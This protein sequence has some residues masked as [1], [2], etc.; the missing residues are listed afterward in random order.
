M[1]R[2]TRGTRG[3]AGTAGGSRCAARLTRRIGR[4]RR[5][6]LRWRYIS[7]ARNRPLAGARP[8]RRCGYWSV[9]GG[10]LSRRVNRGIQQHRVFTDET[11]T[12]PVHLHEES[13]EWLCNGVRGLELD[14]LTTVR[15]T[16][17]LHLHAAEKNGPIQAVSGERLARSDL[18]LERLHL[19]RR[20]VHQLDFCIERRIER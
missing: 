8:R 19:L 11:P 1:S 15:T 20:Y 9:V 12:S 16:R 10:R 13:D 18:R 2:T 14:D 5:R 6:V 7:P 4:Y 3:A 17:G